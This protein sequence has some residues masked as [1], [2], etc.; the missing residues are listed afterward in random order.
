MLLCHLQEVDGVVILLSVMQLEGL[1]NISNCITTLGAVGNWS[2]DHL[3]TLAGLLKQVGLQR[4]SAIQLYHL[5]A[6]CVKINVNSYM[7]LHYILF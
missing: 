7:S 3:E 2:T 4:H 5:H 1:Q 6:H